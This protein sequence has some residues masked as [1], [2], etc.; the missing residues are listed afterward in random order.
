M[1]GH[2]IKGIGLWV[3]LN[4]NKE[5][6]INHENSNK[7]SKECSSDPSL[8]VFNFTLANLP[9]KPSAIPTTKVK[10]D[11]RSN[12]PEKNKAVAA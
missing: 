3:D 5:K 10:M 2:K 6:A 9:S 11:A 8:L 4:K 1:N 12:L 7:R